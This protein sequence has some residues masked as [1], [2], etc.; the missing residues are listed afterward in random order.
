MKSKI[1]TP[2]Y[3]NKVFYKDSEKMNEI[4]NESIDLIVTSPPYFNLKDYS[5]DGYQINKHSKLLN[6]DAGHSKS[7]NQY[8]STLLNV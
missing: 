2:E 7:F 6:G 5:K 3:L 8:L 1:V 4:P